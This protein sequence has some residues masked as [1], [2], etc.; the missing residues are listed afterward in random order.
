VPAANEIEPKTAEPMREFFHHVRDYWEQNP[1]D[2][3]LRTIYERWAI[4][5]LAA[6]QYAV[7]HLA[8]AVAELPACVRS[9]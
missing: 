8:D 7:L 2:H 4:Q 1:G 6:L 9:Q 5:E 3:D